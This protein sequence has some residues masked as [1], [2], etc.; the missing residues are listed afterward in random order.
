MASK[1]KQLSKDHVDI[2]DRSLTQSLVEDQKLLLQ[3]LKKEN[4]QLLSFNP[5]RGRYGETSEERLLRHQK[6]LKWTMNSKQQSINR[7]T[8]ELVDKIHNNIQQETSD[9][10]RIIRPQLLQWQKIKYEPVNYETAVINK[11]LQIEEQKVQAQERKELRDSHNSR[12]QSKLKL[13]EINDIISRFKMKS[14]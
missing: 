8:L 12:L 2:Y 7:Q 14:F 3:D 4:K 13:Q 11:V 6:Y 10:V 1:L 9:D 5:K